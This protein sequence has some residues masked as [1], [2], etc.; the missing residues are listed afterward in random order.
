MN[1][2]SAQLEVARSHIDYHTQ[3]FGYSKP[4][5]DFREGYIEQLDKTGLQDDSFDI[6]V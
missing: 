5:V 2:I 1:V 4:N 3:Q 6:I